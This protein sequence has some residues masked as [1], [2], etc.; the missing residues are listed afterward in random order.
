MYFYKFRFLFCTLWSLFP[1]SELWNG[2]FWLAPPLQL[3]CRSL[4][5]S[6]KV[7]ASITS[8]ISR[9]QTPSNLEVQFKKKKS[10]S[11]EQCLLGSLLSQGSRG[12]C[13]HAV[14]V[15]QH[16]GLCVGFPVTHAAADYVLLHCSV[17]LLQ[18]W[19][20]VAPPR[21]VSDES[22][23][24]MMH[25]CWMDEKKRYRVPQTILRSAK[26]MVCLFI[27]ALISSVS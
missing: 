5:L 27:D 25:K 21:K 14:Q 8:V 4:H 3:T 17:T 16:F 22:F 12:L 24:R 20:A 23:G 26:V 9:E 10:L 19:H 2:L 18:L 1:L 13:L 11:A 7:W 6:T 15:C